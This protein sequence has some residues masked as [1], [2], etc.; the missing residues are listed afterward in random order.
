MIDPADVNDLQLEDVEDYSS[1]Y[2]PPG[3]P[4]GEDN[5]HNPGEVEKRN[6]RRA[7]VMELLMKNKWVTGF[8][9]LLTVVMIV[10]ISILAS[11]GKEVAESR[12]SSSSNANALN[13]TSPVKIDPKTLD[14][15]VSTSLLNNLLDTYEHHGID[16]DVLS[17]TSKAVTPQKQAFWWLAT[18]RKVESY[19]HTQTMQRYALATFYYSTNTV[20][21]LYAEDPKPWKDATL[22]LSDGDACSWHGIECNANGHVTGIDLEN[23]QL[24]GSLTQ[25]LAILA[26]SLVTLD[27]TTNQIYMEG[28]MYHI[29][30]PLTS[31]ETLLLDNNYMVSD[32]GLPKQFKK[33]HKLQKLRMSYNLLSGALEQD[34]H[35]VL[36]HMGELT[37]LELESNFLTGRIPAAIP[38]MTNLM[39]LYLRRNNMEFNLNFLKNAKF[40][41]LFA[42][43]LD[44][45]TITGSIPT[46]IGNF[47][48]LTSLSITNATL[49]GA[50]PSEMGELTDLR[51][52]WLYSNKLTGKIP[53]QMNRCTALEVLELHNNDLT[54][55]MPEKVCTSVQGSD[56][57]YK[58]LTSDCK[59]EVNCAADCCTKCY[60]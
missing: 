55:S 5:I 32:T 44:T 17:E 31:L 45:N 29:F 33:L 28:N 13:P 50:I 48:G 3:F 60:E 37:H 59:S 35:H 1:D 56:Y 41:D 11:A 12:T 14:P 9:A 38:E 8:G 57:K 6:Y 30:E 46:E 36:T 22:W 4:N 24:S 42:L 49:I 2:P 39:Y 7:K 20:K 10:I 15:D 54:G 19:T 27:L 52:L 18:D 25:E 26:D 23:N 51:R 58:A 53:H 40:A 47:K 16:S 43:W 34:G 21:H